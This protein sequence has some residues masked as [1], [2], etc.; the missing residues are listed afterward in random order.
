MVESRLGRYV[1]SVKTPQT[2]LTP[3]SIVGHGLAPSY[4]VLCV[5]GFGSFLLLPVAL[6]LACE[7]TRNAELSS[8]AVGSIVQRLYRSLTFVP[9]LWF[10]A[11]AFTVLFVLGTFWVPAVIDNPRS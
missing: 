6:E 10:S 11:N 1:L 3:K 5:A 8:S 9:Q 7:V 2:S 4:V